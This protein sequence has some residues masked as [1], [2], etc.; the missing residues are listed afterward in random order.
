VIIIEGDTSGFEPG[1]GVLFLDRDGVI[2]VD[3]GWI[4]KIEDFDWM[5]GIFDLARAAAAAGMPVIVVTNQGGIARGLYD[6]SAFRTLTTWM[7]EAFT[8]QGA[9]IARVIACPHHPDGTI[10]PLNI[11]CACRKP[12]PGMLLQ[13][14]AD[15]NID[16]ARSILIGDNASDIEAGY[17][18]GVVRKHLLLTTGNSIAEFTNILK[19]SNNIVI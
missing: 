6:E 11:K 17:K 13:C 15:F 8:A 9:P 19:L 2:N 5:P 16:P 7:M 1:C 14:I 12:A 10:A 18:A 3:H 4:H